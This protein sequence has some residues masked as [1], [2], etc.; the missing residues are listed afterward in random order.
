MENELVRKRLQNY[1]LQ[2]DRV[3]DIFK[4]YEVIIHNRVR[5]YLS[6]VGMHNLNS[7]YEQ[8]NDVSIPVLLQTD[9]LDETIPAPGFQQLMFERRLKTESFKTLLNELKVDNEELAITLRSMGPD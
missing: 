4:E 6:D 9:V 2:E 3:L 1:F 5:P 7:L 8:S